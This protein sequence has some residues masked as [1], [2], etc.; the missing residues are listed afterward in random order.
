[1]K[2]ILGGI[3]VLVLI[4]GGF[5]FNNK[6]NSE[7][8]ELVDH[9]FNNE[10]ILSNAEQEVITNQFKQQFKEMYENKK[11]HEIYEEM[12]KYNPTS[13]FDLNGNFITSK[14]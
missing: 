9:L 12:M 1:M 7:E 3:L 8:K 6:I 10:V 5:L 2:K 13:I 4:A 14:E 11:Y